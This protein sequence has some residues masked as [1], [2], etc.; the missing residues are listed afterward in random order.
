MKRNGYLEKLWFDGKGDGDASGGAW[1][2]YTRGRRQKDWGYL[3]A[4]AARYGTTYLG[5]PPTYSV[6]YDTKQQETENCPTSTQS[7][8]VQQPSRSTESRQVSDLGRY[9]YLRS[10]WTRKRS[11]GCKELTWYRAH[12]STVKLPNNLGPEQHF[13]YHLQNELPE[14]I[15][16]ELGFITCAYYLSRANPVRR[17]FLKLTVPAFSQLRNLLTA[18]QRLRRLVDIAL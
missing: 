6:R 2:V 5:L 14:V 7:D 18:S 10:H 12:L 13:T 15:L 17:T 9:N 8:E 1:L 11:L 16:F 3:F 4:G